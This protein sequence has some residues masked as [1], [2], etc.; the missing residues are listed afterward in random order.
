MST[1]DHPETD[2]QTERVN[3]V[4]EDILRSV[5]SETPRRWGE[6]LLL[7]EFALNNAVHA[8]TGFTPFNVKCQ[9]V[10]EPSCPADAATSW[11]WA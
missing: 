5:C 2:G 7:A 3:R 9:R 10:G 8:S 6:M 11:L 4:M 1:A